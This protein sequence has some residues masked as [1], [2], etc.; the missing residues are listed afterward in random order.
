MKNVFL[1]LAAIIVSVTLVSFNPVPD[2][3]HE[4][5]VDNSIF[6]IL[7]PG[8]PEKKE[9]FVTSSLGEL[10]VNILMLQPPEGTDDNLMYM[11]SYTDYPIDHVNSDSTSL[12]EKLFDSF[13]EGSI[14]A[15][16]GKLLIET[17]IDYKDYP[18]REEI[19]NFKYKNGLAITKI[20]YYI[21]KNRLYTLQVITLSAKNFNASIDK[22]MDSF[23]L[24]DE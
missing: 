5:S 16:N 7:M 11:L 1:I 21:I 15:V 3:W 10:K 2:E 23:K 24:T 14:N 18:G 4:Y 6:T 20:R 8:K 17:I 9:K 12:L 13:R 19:V 22:F